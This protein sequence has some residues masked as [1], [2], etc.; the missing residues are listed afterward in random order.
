MVGLMSWLPYLAYSPVRQQQDFLDRY[1][2]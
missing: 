1:R 2:C